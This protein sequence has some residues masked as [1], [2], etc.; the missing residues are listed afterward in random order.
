MQP[1]AT[2]L[3]TL[4]STTTRLLCWNVNGIRT[5]FGRPP[6]RTELAAFMREHGGADVLCLQETKLSALSG[7]EDAA[8][9]H[10]PACDT[11]Y[12]HSDDRKGYSGTAVVAP[13]GTAVSATTGV[14]VLEDNE[15]RAVVVDLGVF[16]LVNLYCPNGGRN[17]E[18]KFTFY[19]RLTA[20]LRKLHWDDGRELV[21]CGDMN[22]THKPIDLWNPE[23]NKASIGCTPKERALL[24]LLTADRESGGVALVD[25]FRHLHGDVG[26]A[27]TF[28][29]MRT[30]KRPTNQGWRIDYFY[31]TPGLVSKVVAA[32]ILAD[33]QGSD[34]CPIAL[35][36]DVQLERG[37][38]PVKEA[39]N[40][41]FPK[42]RTITSFF[43][44]KKR[45]AAE[46][47]AAAAADGEKTDERD[48]KRAKPAVA[49][50]KK[51]KA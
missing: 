2:T 22:V 34:H 12:C 30:N 38:K 51:G 50:K 5:V 39:A 33:V 11:F 41:R 32:E 21:V 43:A 10:V 42:A 44:P 13:A 20:Y 17:L 47:V 9:I 23:K 24:D 36:L 35:T 48:K 49:E 28:W 40:R 19:E 46:A 37:R 25:T 15:G 8:L 6:A 1:A 16:V 27:Y 18:Y 29:D 31:V 14:E 26:D 7:E 3:P 4:T 45:A